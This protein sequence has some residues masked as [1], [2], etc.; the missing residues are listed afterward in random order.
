M[1][2]DVLTPT[3]TSSPLC[4]IGIVGLV[5]NAKIFRAGSSKYVCCPASCESCGGADCWRQQGGLACCAAHLVHERDTPSC[6]QPSDVGCVLPPAVPRSLIVRATSVGDA[7]CRDAWSTAYP[8]ER[9]DWKGHSCAFKVKWGQCSRFYQECQ[10]SCGYCQ[11]LSSSCGPHAPANELPPNGLVAMGSVTSSSNSG[12]SSDNTQELLSGGLALRGQSS[13]ADDVYLQHLPHVRRPRR[14]RPPPLPM[15]T[16]PSAPHPQRS[17]WPMPP[18]SQLWSTAPPLPLPMPLPL[19]LPPPSPVSLLHRPTRYQTADRARPMTPSE[20][21]ERLLPVALHNT[22]KFQPWLERGAEFAGVLG[23]RLN[24]SRGVLREHV[25]PAVRLAG[26]HASHHARSKVGPWLDESWNMTVKTLRI[27]LA[28]KQLLDERLNLPWAT[29]R[30]RPTYGELLEHIAKWN[31]GTLVIV[32][33]VACVA[34]ALLLFSCWR[35]GMSTL[36]AGA[37]RRSRKRRVRET[38]AEPLLE[39]RQQ[40]G[41]GEPDDSSDA[42]VIFHPQSGPSAAVA[43]LLAVDGSAEADGSG[44]SS[45]AYPQPMGSA[46]GPTAGSARLRAA[47]QSASTTPPPKAEPDQTLSVRAEP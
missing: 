23:A 17:L 27:R 38:L 45:D 5:H 34:I 44:D 6:E 12:S 35:Q 37:R 31:P 9:D 30:D 4:A 1:E 15:P 24:R 46:S 18:P 47:D 16:L 28:Q 25:L 40:P 42:D 13:V 41:S 10:C 33:C 36:S 22:S 14:P 43:T 11:P 8:R 7:S 3:L 29:S 21:S 19:H 2:P 32:A 26:D 39:E 20:V